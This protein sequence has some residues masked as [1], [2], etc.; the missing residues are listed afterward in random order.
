MGIAST[1]RPGVQFGA[2]FFGPDDLTILGDGE[3]TFEENV[4]SGARVR[5]IAEGRSIRIGARAW[6]GD[7]ATIRGNVGTNSIVTAKSVVVGD[8]PDNVVAEGNPAQ[9]VWQI[10]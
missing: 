8:V 9:K 2:G 1:D 4:T 3:V 10:C 6:L 7:D 5:I